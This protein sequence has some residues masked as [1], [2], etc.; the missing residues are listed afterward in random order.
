[1]SVC[2]CVIGGWNWDFWYKVDRDRWQSRQCLNTRRSKKR[3]NNLE[4]KIGHDAIFWPAISFNRTPAFNN[5]IF[6]PY[7]SHDSA[8]RNRLIMSFIVNHLYLDQ[9]PNTW[10]RCVTTH[11][12]MTE[13]KV[14]ET[15]EINFWRCARDNMK[16]LSQKLR[17]AS[18]KCV[19][20][21]KPW[22]DNKLIRLEFVKTDTRWILFLKH[23]T[24]ETK[25][26]SLIKVENTKRKKIKL[27]TRNFLAAIM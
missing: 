19:N 27:Y 5:S 14:R 12:Q 23:F 8:N 7:C 3:N 16:K 10:T 15:N 1:M 9:F 4:Q 11:P 2:V 18:R 21:V 22:S 20:G 26:H 24:T 13:N 25:S 6:L 17:L